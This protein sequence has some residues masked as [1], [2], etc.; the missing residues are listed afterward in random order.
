MSRA[1]NQPRDDFF[2]A[3]TIFPPTTM[4]THHRRL[5]VLTWAAIWGLLTVHSIGCSKPPEQVTTVPESEVEVVTPPVEEKP[6]PEVVWRELVEKTSAHLE[7]GELDEAE[8]CIAEFAKVFEEPLAPSE[9]RQ[10]ELT[11]LNATLAAKREALATQQ[12]EEDLVEAER[13]ME[14]GKLTEAVQKLNEVKALAPTADQRARASAVATRIENLRRARRDLQS[15]L[16]MLGSD[17]ERDVAAAQTNLLKRPEI[18]LGML[19]EASESIDNPVL[20]GNALVA[21][22]SMNQPET[23]VPAMIGVLRRTEQQQVW[24]VAIREL[25]RMNRPG[26][27]DPLLELALS[28]GP[29]EQRVA[30]LTA[31]SQVSDPPNHTLVAMLPTLLQNGPELTAALRATYHA[32]RIHDQY[33]LQARFGLDAAL[34]AEQEQQLSQRLAELVAL[35]AGNEETAEVIQ[36]A[37]VLACAIRQLTPQPLT[38]VQ[39]RYAEAQADDGPATAVLDGVWNSVDLATMWRHPVAETSTILL[40]LGQTRTVVGVRIWNFNQAAG[41]QRGWKDVDIFVSDSTTEADPIAR[42]VVPPAPG[43]ADTPDYSTTVPIPFARGRYVRLQAKKLWA[44]D[45]YTG[46]SEIQILGF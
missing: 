42:G 18:A 5:S 23:T 22:R 34:N 41:T 25:V 1:H 9:E 33:D 31:L 17:R 36:A 12:R 29:P 40:D 16:R 35:P 46:L 24:P 10:A 19:L 26:A 4:N 2:P 6:D 20:A 30:A 37:Q 8:Q 11:E 27:G 44:T 45:T 13:L 43:A 7:A 28:G 14:L 32:L 21:L 3:A 38:D 15:W 39:V